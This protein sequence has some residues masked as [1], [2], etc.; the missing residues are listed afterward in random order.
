M[1]REER[2]PQVIERLGWSFAL[3]YH[4]G[5]GRAFFVVPSEAHREILHERAERFAN[6]PYWSQRFTL[7]EPEDF[8]LR[9]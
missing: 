7:I 1:V 8:D 2:L 6:D 4:P 5:T 3:L 9:G